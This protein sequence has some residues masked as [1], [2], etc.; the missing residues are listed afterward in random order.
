MTLTHNERPAIEIQGLWKRYGLP[1]PRLM[2]GLLRGLSP[3]SERTDTLPWA[4]RN[5][6]L[7]IRRGENL[8]IIGGNGSGKSTL[9]KILAGVTPPTRGD[10]RVDGRV[11]PMIELQAGINP[12]LTGRENIELLGAVMGY[13]PSDIAKRYPAI[14][15]FSELD[16]WLDRPVRMYSSGMQARLAFSVAINTEA[17]ILLIDEILGVGDYRFQKKCVERLE[18]LRMSR[19]TTLVFVSHNPYQVQRLCDRVLLLNSGEQVQ[20]DEASRALELYFGRLGAKGAPRTESSGIVLPAVE[21]RDGSGT[22]RIRKIDLHD[23]AGNIV[24]A[25]TTGESATLRLHY[26]LA[27]PVHDPNFGIRIFDSQ[28][29]CVLSF[30]Y[31]RYL[32]GSTLQSD[33]YV[34]CRLAE[35]PLLTGSYLVQ[36]K[37]AG[38]E[39]YD[40]IQSAPGLEVNTPPQ[41]MIDT[42]NLGLF[43]GRA[44][45]S[46][47]QGEAGSA[48][49]EAG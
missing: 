17:D 36:V 21:H 47:V 37:V 22:L 27:D 20:L 2:R 7:T 1:I 8:G 32:D 10:V 41:V 28:N 42:A 14:A 39:L 23:S 15:E 49:R 12:D 25:L 6:D 19:R 46:L 5:L 18:Q 30:A 9:L 31:T 40:F 35:V 45:W 48:D 44:C 24:E 34:D 3:A 13:C 11:F 43:Y 16:E 26:S 38:D 4:L 33:G 29:T